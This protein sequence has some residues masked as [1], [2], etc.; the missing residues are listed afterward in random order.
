MLNLQNIQ[1]EINKTK[2]SW[3]TYNDKFKGGRKYLLDYAK[4]NN[5][6]EAS[7][8][9]VKQANINARKSVIEQN[10][11]LEKM[12]IGARAAKLGLDALSMAG[13]M[14]LITLIS[15]G[16][17]L[18][19]KAIDDSIHHIENIKKRQKKQKVQLM[20]YEIVLKVILALLMK[21]KGVMQNLHK[22]LRI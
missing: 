10:A 8:D 21:Q 1:Q 20:I 14:I 12:T 4:A 15:K 5:V 16:I 22:V 6:L 2:G 3:D 9:D 18:A 19:I 7:V 13:N 11:S 17:E